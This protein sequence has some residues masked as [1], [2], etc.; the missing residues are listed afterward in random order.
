MYD[1]EIR[2]SGKGIIL[3]G[4]PETH[5]GMDL[6]TLKKLRDVIDDYLSSS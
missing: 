5:Y 1:F 6:E 3:M 2:K 4:L